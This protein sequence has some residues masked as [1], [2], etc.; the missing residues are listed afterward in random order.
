[1][2]AIQE[3]LSIDEPRTR[4]ALAAPRTSMLDRSLVGAAVLGAGALE[5]WFGRTDMGSVYGSDA[6]QY[7]DIARA[8]EAGQWKLAMNPLWGLGYPLLLTGL[9]PA[10]PRGMTGDL[11]AVRMLNVAIF[12]ATW[13]KRI[14]TSFG[15]AR[16]LACALLVIALSYGMGFLSYHLYEKHFLRFGRRHFAPRQPSPAT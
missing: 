13:I 15:D 9:R 16:M 11:L 4:D 14:A 8:L 6:V 3:P 2:S 7:L 1:M 5:C 12:A 10:F